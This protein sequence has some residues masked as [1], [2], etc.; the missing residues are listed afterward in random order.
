MSAPGGF[1][2]SLVEVTELILDQ[3]VSA[4]INDA[5]ANEVTAP[6]TTEN[7]WSPARIVWLKDFH[8]TRRSGLN[9]PAGEITWAIVLG[10][11]VVGS[12][13]LK[14]TAV[15]GILET[16]IWLARRIRGQGVGK[17]A[18]TEVLRRAAALGAL[19]VQADTTASNGAALG[20]LRHLSFNLVRGDAG[21]G[22]KAVLMFDTC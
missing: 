8:R 11:H 9:G 7:E 19:G 18:M 1:G 12:V 13:R 4:A 14:Q 20:V 15:P 22:I 21:S 17:C 3:L 2:M 16:G 5:S 10:D 6:V